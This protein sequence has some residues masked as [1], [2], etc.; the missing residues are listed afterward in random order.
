MSK[1]SPPK[2]PSDALTGSVR[3]FQ[4]VRGSDVIGRVQP[5]FDWQDLRRQHNL[6]SYSKATNTAPTAHSEATSDSG[7]TTS[8][9]NFAS[10][11]YLSLSSHDAVKEAAKAAI[12]EFGVHS[13]GSGALLGNTRYSLQLEQVISDFLG[14]EHTV[15]YP[16]GWSAGFGVV[17]GLIR[18]NDHV[19]MDI[20][21][22]SCL[23]E[24]AKAATKNIHFHGHL[25]I[26]RARQK[27]EKI[28]AKDTKNAIM[29]ITESQFSMH[30]DTPDL[31][32]LQDVCRA[33]DA[34]L[35]IDVAHDLGCIGDTG[36]GQL[37]LQNMLGEADLIIGSF[38]K[39]F[40]S[41]GGFV[42]TRSQAVKEY[43]KYYS[44]TQTFSNA[45]SPVQA[46]IVLKAF[47]IIKSEEG[48]ALRRKLM[49]NILYLRAELEKAR[50][51]VTGVPCAVVPVN[52]GTEGSARIA[53]RRLA[54]LAAIVNL[55]EYPAVPKG[56]ARFRLQVMAAHSKDDI[57]QLVKLMVTAVNE[58]EVLYRPHRERLATATVKAAKLK[59]VA[60]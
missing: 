7:V 18:P 13:A 31:R 44:A 22:H 17:Q 15:L 8:G 41:N 4:E 58:A 20:L 53:A 49:D 38:S 28:R 47:E 45:M 57:D 60:A 27:L 9:V 35:V 37:G 21:T 59:G 3:N 32:G 48:A 39:S 36:H 6:W 29:V 46:A 33:Y 23:Q 5:F 2:I 24:G 50:L 55:V 16:T 34:T 43:L 51:E 25:N 1:T 19:L 14:C 40:A 52:I 30:A 26:N 56:N 42:A 12:D 54:E 10:Q 11:D